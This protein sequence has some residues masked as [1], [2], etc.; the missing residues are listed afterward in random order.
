M[1]NI[2]DDFDESQH[3]EYEYKKAMDEVNDFNKQTEAMKK[4]TANNITAV[5]HGLEVEH[6][7]IQ[8]NW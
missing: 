3:D 2:T 5:E 1:I 6:E 8:T 4:R 7:P